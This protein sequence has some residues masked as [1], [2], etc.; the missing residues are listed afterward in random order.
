MLKK[1]LNYLEPCVNTGMVSELIFQG[2]LITY[3]L[4]L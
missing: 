1:I 4:Q 3:D 2:K